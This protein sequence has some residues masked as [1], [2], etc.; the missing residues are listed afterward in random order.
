MVVGAMLEFVAVI[1]FCIAVNSISFLYGDMMRAD[2]EVLEWW[3]GMCWHLE[4]SAERVG[5]SL[6]FG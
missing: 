1:C 2:V 3:H 5:F 6:V 4:V